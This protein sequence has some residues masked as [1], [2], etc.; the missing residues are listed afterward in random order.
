MEFGMA[1]AKITVTVGEDQLAA[2]RSLVESGKAKS[3]S[4]FVQH[5]VGVSLADV[6]GWGAMLGAALEQTGGPLTRK[7]RAWADSILKAGP[8]KKRRHKAA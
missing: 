1:T 6:A 2:I 4:G 5:A 8:T 7:E 3:V